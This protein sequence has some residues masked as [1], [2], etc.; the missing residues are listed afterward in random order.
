[1][2]ER[3]RMREIGDDEGRRLVQIVRR[4]AGSV[5]TGLRA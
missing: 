2:T 4:G 1:V 3:L 5:V